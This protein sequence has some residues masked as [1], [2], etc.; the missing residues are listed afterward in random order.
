MCVVTATVLVGVYFIRAVDRLD[1][2]GGINASLNYDDRE[3]GGGNS[4]GVDK[5]AL[6]QARELISEGS[7]YRLLTGPNVA[8]ATELTEEYIDQFARYFLMPR[9]PD[10]DARWIFCYG[11]DPGALEA[12]VVWDNG[13]G[14]SLLWVA[15]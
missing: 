1:E 9:R 8:G 10:P 5:R 3:F 7:T 6:Y 4:L 15:G 12:Q 14:I 2:T 11:C 13:G